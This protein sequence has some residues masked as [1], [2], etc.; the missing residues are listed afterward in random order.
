V[1]RDVPPGRYR[2]SVSAQDTGTR[3][4]ESALSSEATVTVP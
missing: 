4:N 1:D 2:Y 3:A